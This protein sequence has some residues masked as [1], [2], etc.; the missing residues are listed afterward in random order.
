MSESKTEII[1]MFPCLRA[2]TVN[3]FKHKREKIFTSSNNGESYLYR[4]SVLKIKFRICS[5]TEESRVIYR[6]IVCVY[7][8]T[9]IPTE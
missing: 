2:T 3:T 7:I 6:E 4:D 5:V 8:Y 9:Y 1:I